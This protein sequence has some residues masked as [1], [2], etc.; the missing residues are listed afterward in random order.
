MP[1]CASLISTLF[2]Q[3]DVYDVLL[4]LSEIS[5]DQLVRQNAMQLLGMMPTDSTVLQQLADVISSKGPAEHMRHLLIE[6][7][8]ATKPAT[9]L[10]TLQVRVHG[11]RSTNTLP[12]PHQ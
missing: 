2:A 9:L 6:T 10:Y 1:T 8:T 11:Q 4:S 7:G 12:V 3:P 5:G